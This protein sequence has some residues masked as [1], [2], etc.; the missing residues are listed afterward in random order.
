MISGMVK[1]SVQIM[2]AIELVITLPTIN[3]LFPVMTHQTIFIAEKFVTEFTIVM[4]NLCIIMATEAFIA[5]EISA[6]VDTEVMYGLRVI[7]QRIS[8]REVFST[9]W[10]IAPLLSRFIICATMKGR[11]S[12]VLL[13]STLVDEMAMT[14]SAIRHWGEEEGKKMILVA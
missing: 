8:R 12:F 5:I 7:D 13:E 11:I 4:V 6:M 14:T 3:V 1:V 2:L 10:A 9:L